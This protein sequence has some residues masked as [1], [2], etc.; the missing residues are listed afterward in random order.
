MKTSFRMIYLISMAMMVPGLA[1]AQSTTAFD[2]TYAGVS[3][4][5][6]GACSPFVP[7]P[8]PLTVKNG[9][10][11]FEGGFVSG[12]TIAFSGSVSP[13]GDLKMQDTLSNTAAGKIDTTGKATASIHFMGENSNCN[14]TGVWQKQ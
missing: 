12:P 8:R 11:Q 14:L 6:G 9:V 2:G 13:Q 10:A 1:S 5:G 7:V 4:S 3:N